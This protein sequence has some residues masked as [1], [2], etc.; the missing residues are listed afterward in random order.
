VHNSPLF[1]AG[2]SV[3]IPVFNATE[4]LD[5]LLRRLI[6]VLDSVSGVAEVLLVEDGS[7]DESWKLIVAL[8]ETYPMVRGIQLMKNYGQHNALLCGIRMAKFGVTVTLDDDLQN[9]PEEIPKLLEALGGDLD[10]VY[11]VPRRTGHSIGRNV[12]SQITR[13]VLQKAMG[14]ET[15]RNV[16]AF[17]AFRTQLREAFTAYRGPH[18]SLDV[19]LSWG[20]SRFGLVRVEHAQRRA[21][22]SNYNLGKLIVHAVNMLTGYTTIPLQLATL[23]GLLFT[24]FGVLVLCF[25]VMRY[26]IEGDPSPGFPFLASAI[27]IFSG[28]QL[29]ALGILGEYIARMY[30]R[31]MDRPSYTIRCTSEELEQHGA[32]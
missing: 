8:A 32:S 5:L 28:A 23:V 2:I 24:G 10:V 3:V 6:P 17:R 30:L 9:P 19:L 1:P 13:L 15:A 4:S 20:T 21:G 25:V 29:F 16:S 12:A 7:R 27:A 22:S 31:S 14:A 26:F 11:G 18:V